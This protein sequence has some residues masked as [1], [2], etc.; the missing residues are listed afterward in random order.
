MDYPGKGDYNFYTRD[1][2][3]LYTAKRRN[4]DGAPKVPV[5]M[6]DRENEKKKTDIPIE[7]LYVEE[8]ESIVGEA[9]GAVVEAAL[10]LTDADFG[11]D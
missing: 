3:H 5:L 2:D 8:D 7:K 6:K 1:K 4:E 11:W 9:I 10:T